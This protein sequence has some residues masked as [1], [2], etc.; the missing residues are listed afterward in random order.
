[1][2]LYVFYFLFLDFL[3]AAMLK[4]AILIGGRFNFFLIIDQLSGPIRI[5]LRAREDMD[6]GRGEKRK[7]LE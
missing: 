7:S 5:D 4:E 3:L 1:M 2:S 6:W